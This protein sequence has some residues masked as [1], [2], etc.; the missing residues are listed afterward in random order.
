[1]FLGPLAYHTD[2]NLITA[3]T[4][5]PWKREDSRAV[6]SIVAP[7]YPGK[8]PRKSFLIVSTLFE[9]LFSLASSAILPNRP[10]LRRRWSSSFRRGSSRFNFHDDWPRLG[11]HAGQ[12]RLRFKHERREDHQKAIGRLGKYVQRGGIYELQRPNEAKLFLSRGN[13][14]F[15][16]LLNH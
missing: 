13:S 10:M 15:V 9:C 2:R 14:L 6:R 12:K 8:K 16:D 4:V 3:I 1:M 7:L 5:R 11:L